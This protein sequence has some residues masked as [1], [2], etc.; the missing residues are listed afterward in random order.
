MAHISEWEQE[1][2]KPVVTTNQAAFWAV[3]QRLG[4]RERCPA[5]GRLL[6]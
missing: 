1:F 4:A 6:A 3:L 5:L 2:K